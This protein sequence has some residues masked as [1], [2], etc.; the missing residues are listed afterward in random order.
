MKISEY[1]I[2]VCVKDFVLRDL[3]CQGFAESIIVIVFNGVFQQICFIDGS[4]M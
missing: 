4:C 2:Q 1:E 3:H